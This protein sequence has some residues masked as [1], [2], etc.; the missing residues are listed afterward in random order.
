MVDHIKVVTVDMVEEVKFWTHC[1]CRASETFLMELKLS[2]RKDVKGNKQ[3]RC[4]IYLLTI[5][6]CIVCLWSVESLVRGMLYWKYLL[7]NNW[8]YEFEVQG[9]GHELLESPYIIGFKVL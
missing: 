4:F 6:L 1:N 3:S 7:V 5:H 9:T 2:I 8:I